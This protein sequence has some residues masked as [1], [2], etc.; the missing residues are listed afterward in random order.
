[1]D[2]SLDFLETWPYVIYHK[3]DGLLIDSDYK[4]EW[5]DEATEIQDFLPLNESN[6]NLLR[7]LLATEDLS[8]LEKLLGMWVSYDCKMINYPFY[9][10][11][12]FGVSN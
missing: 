9:I 8:S 12:S 11:D 4:G 3:K 7:M 1:M 2:N 5:G 10:A 6:K